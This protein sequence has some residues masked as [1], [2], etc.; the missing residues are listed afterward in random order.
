[1]KAALII[2][3]LRQAHQILDLGNPM[4]MRRRSIL[5]QVPAWVPLG[6][7][8]GNSVAAVLDFVACIHQRTFSMGAEYGQTVITVGYTLWLMLCKSQTGSFPYPFM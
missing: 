2:P 7:H 3:V 8:V 6:M 1:M 5:L 4:A